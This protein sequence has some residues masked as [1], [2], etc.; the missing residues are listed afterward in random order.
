MSPIVNTT[1][2]YGQVKGALNAMSPED[3]GATQQRHANPNLGEESSRL[4]TH[5]ASTDGRQGFQRLG[6][7]NADDVLHLF[8]T[9]GNY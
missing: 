5:H 8:N 2:D 9:C 3:V 7:G 4:V 6:Q 1:C